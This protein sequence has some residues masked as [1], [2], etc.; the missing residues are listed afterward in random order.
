VRSRSLEIAE[1]LCNKGKPNEAVPYLVK[2]MKD[3]N[4]LDAFIQCA[5]LCPTLDESVECIETGI[6]KGAFD[7]QISS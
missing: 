6:Q 2:A 1:A 7:Y 4:N 3:G 5:F